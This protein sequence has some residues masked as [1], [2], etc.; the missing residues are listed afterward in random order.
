MDETPA[1]RLRALV[2][3]LKAILDEVRRLG[4]GAE[5]QAR[6]LIDPE[7][8]LRE[9]AEYGGSASADASGSVAM[10]CAGL[11][12]LS[13]VAYQIYQDTHEVQYLLDSAEYYLAAKAQGCNG[14]E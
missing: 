11:Y 14:H 7:A 10:S 12:T 5:R 2:P 13:A 3:H 8:L 1:Q 6:A 4:P 9:R